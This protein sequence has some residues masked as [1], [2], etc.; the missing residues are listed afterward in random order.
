MFRGRRIHA[1]CS[2][3]SADGRA[4]AGGRYLRP[5]SHSSMTRGALSSFLS[6]LSDAESAYLGGTVLALLVV[7]GAHREPNLS[8]IIVF[9]Y[10]D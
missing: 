3:R 9:S 8:L 2:G 4:A 1:R 10:C 6:D 5:P 7:C